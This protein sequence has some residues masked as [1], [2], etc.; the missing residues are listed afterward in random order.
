MGFDR[1]PQRQPKE[2][3][4]GSRVVGIESLMTPSQERASD[5]REK[6]FNKYAEGDPEFAKKVAMSSLNY[7]E[8]LSKNDAY[9]NEL[10]VAGGE[11]SKVYKINGSING[12]IVKMELW[13]TR[14]KKDTLIAEVA[15]EKLPYDR[16]AMIWN[17]Y[18]DVAIAG[19][20]LKENMMYGEP[21]SRFTTE[22]RPHKFDLENRITEELG[23]VDTKDMENSQKEREKERLDALMEDLGLG[24]AS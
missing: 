19:D 9:G 3:G 11:R 20:E 12:R 15:G 16:G 8:N 23:P 6:I 17:A 14:G 2:K 4:A 21:G 22:G 5:M 1:P 13:K 10:Y 7:S 18:I 24:V